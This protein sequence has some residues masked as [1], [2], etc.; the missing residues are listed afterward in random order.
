MALLNLDNL[1]GVTIGS[2][3]VMMAIVYG[4]IS[5]RQT[6]A[7]LNRE[8]GSSLSGIAEGLSARL[9]NDM[10]ARAT[11][12]QSLSR[13]AVLVQPEIAQHII[14]QL[15]T[16]DPALAWAGVANRDGIVIAGT[17]G[18]LVGL[19]VAQRPVYREGISGLFLGD[20]HDAALLANLLPNKTGEPMRFVDVSAPIQGRDGNAIGI[21][22]IHYSWD[23]ARRLVGASQTSLSSRS[24]AETV[25]VAADNNVLLGPPALLGTVLKLDSIEQ[26]RSG[27]V[28][29]HLER[30]PDGREY[31]TG[32]AANRPSIVKGLGWT[33]L[34]RQPVDVAHAPAHD[35]RNMIFWSGLALAVTFGVLGWLIS[36]YITSPLRAIVSAAGAILNGA[37]G[38]VVP[39]VRGAKEIKTLSISIRELGLNLGASNKALVATHA[40]LERLESIAYQDRLTSLPN[41]RFFEQ[42]LEAAIVRAKAADNQIVIL[43]LDLDGFKLVNDQF[44]HDVGDQVLRNV[45]IRLASNLRQQDFIARIGGDEF[46][47]VLVEPDG[48]LP[49]Q[50]ARRLIHALSEPM[51]IQDHPVEIGCTIG[52]ARW[53][54]DGDEVADVIRLADAALYLAKR[55]GKNRALFHGEAVGRK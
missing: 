48:D 50:L 1:L 10:Q 17:R 33:V 51:H 7:V 52:A 32:Y 8:V 2:I 30:W 4:L 29:W 28:G 34:V 14:D 15:S 31:M 3:V 42:Y 23:W 55:Q 43:Y 9:N 19:S 5:D 49:H 26:A 37:P 12:V 21:I 41:R 44:G 39:E 11:I 36:H 40:A 22:A 27:R 24:D 53:P 38:S 45:G 20:V 47:C 46:A 25:L 35:L 13:V 16:Q 6:E 54:H 18:I